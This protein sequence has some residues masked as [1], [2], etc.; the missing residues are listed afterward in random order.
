MS[1]VTDHAKKRIRKRIGPKDAE[2]NFRQ[3]LV[4]GTPLKDTKGNLKRYLTRKAIT[5]QSDAIVH[6]N[7]VYWHKKTVLLTVIP[8]PQK[9]IK[10]IKKGKAD[11]RK[12]KNTVA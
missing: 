2:K 12:A 1:G 11:A 7:Y 6:K 3:A 4:E 5:H 10:Y 9:F 8:L